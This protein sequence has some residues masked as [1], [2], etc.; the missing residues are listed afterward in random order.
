[1]NDGASTQDP[2]QVDVL[3]VGAG[4][5]GLAVAIEA[6]QGGRSAL[7]VEAT[8]RVGGVLEISSG[9]MSAAGTMLQRARGI[10]DSP[11]DHFR[12]IVRIAGDRINKPMV[13]MAVE[14]APVTIDWLCI[15]GFE[16][17][18]SCP[19]LYHFH[20]A[21]SVPRTYWGVE[22]GLS[23]LTVLKS[24][25]EPLVASGA[26]QLL[27]ETRCT[28]LTMGSAGR[29]DAA[30]IEGPSGRRELHVQDVVIAAGGHTESP[31]ALRRFT[32]TEKVL[33]GGWTGSTGTMIPVLDSI[34]ATYWGEKVFTPTYG[35][36]EEPPH[37]GRVSRSRMPDLVPQSRLPWEIHVSTT[38]ERF[39]QEDVV[40]VDIRE[41]ALAQLKPM[42]FWIIGDALIER[43]SPP[44][45]PSWS[46]DEIAAAW[47]GY[48][49]FV[50]ADTLD[51]LA[52]ACG[53]D[54]ARLI[55]TVEHY[56]RAV[57]GELPDVLGRTHLPLPIEHGPFWAIQ[58]HGSIVKSFAGVC[59]DS[60]LRVITEAGPLE[61]LYAVGEALG[62]ATMS[63]ETFV[64]GMSLTP[65]LSFGREIGQRLAGTLTPSILEAK[66]DD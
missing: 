45:L 51:G 33:S 44:L 56:N 55:A 53:I 7:L 37:S 32:T 26:V 65:A 57:R 47:A 24:L 8:D 61:N 66:D 22:K 5:A 18:S 27:L 58:N 36:I 21:Y 63:N 54:A 6:A 38:G 28:G 52:T 39:V 42:A 31:S 20:E 2:V 4:A 16:M 14:L 15:N 50:R 46:A 11:E 25:L 64:G 59:V 62:G 17:E 30:T 9:Q 12:D 48:P 13:R 19:A 34:G 40:S 43:E 1:M 60:S 41:K 29:V 23:V 49:G 35:G 3:I 10:E